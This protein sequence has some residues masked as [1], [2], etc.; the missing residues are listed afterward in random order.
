MVGA[1]PG[2]NLAPERDRALVQQS[3]QGLLPVTSL[4]GRQPWRVY[5]RPFDATEARP[6]IAVILTRLGLS[7]AAT[8]TAIQALPAA[9]TLAFAPYSENLSHWINLAR[10]AGHEVLLDLPMEP[11]DYP[12]DDPG[13]HALMTS[14]SATQNLNHLEWTLGRVTGYIGVN[15]TNGLR[16]TASRRDLFPVL[17]ALKN[18]G[19]MFVD[20]RQGSRSRTQQVADELGLPWT[21]NNRV[22]DRVASRPAIDATLAEVERIAKVRGKAIATGFPY[23]VTIER[24]AAWLRTFEEKGLVAAP[25]SALSSA[26]PKR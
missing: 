11:L 9:V 26:G 20:G 4:G 7:S 5:A 15:I 14:L 21:A 3:P 22:I 13:P 23:P 16:I 2:L 6:K 18:R 8:A 10:A 19:L 12:R 25:V 1:T 17:K 24:L